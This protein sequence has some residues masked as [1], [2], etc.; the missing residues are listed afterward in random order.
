MNA[1]RLTPLSRHWQLLALLVAVLPQYDRLPPWLTVSVLAV[2]LWRLAPVERRLGVPGPWLRGLLLLAGMGGVLYS[3]HTLLGPEGGVSFL[4]VCALLKLLE[5]STPR[6]AFV[7]AVLDFFVLATAFLFSQA[8]LLTLYVGMASIVVVAALLSLQQRPGV[9]L[10]RTLRRAT[11]LVVQAVPLMLVLFVFFPRLPP[12]WTLNLTQGS[13]HTGMSDS[14]SPGDISSLSESA[15]TAF[16]VEFQGPPP[17]A[18]TLYWRGLVFSHFDGK[19][20]SQPDPISE[21]VPTR[22]QQVPR[23]V[24]G[25]GGGRPLSYRVILEATDQPWL[26]ALNVPRPVTAKVGLT[27][28][29]R[30]VYSEPVRSTLSYEVQSWPGARVDA[31][32]L[33]LWLR[34]LNLQ[35]PAGGNPEARRMAQGWRLSAGSDERYVRSILDWFRQE[36]FYYTLEAPPLGEDRIDD[37]LFRTRRGFCEHYASSF[38]FL[39]RAAGIPARV[40]AGYQGG[41]AGTLGDYWLVRQLDAHAWAEVWLPGRGWVRE[42]PTAAVAPV[43]IQKGADQVAAQRSYWGEGAAGALRHGN[44]RLLKGLRQFADY[45][46]YRWHRDVLGYDSQSQEGLM[47]RLLGDTGLLRRLA[48]MVAVLAA[49]AGLIFLWTLRSGQ[50]EQHPLD[51]LYRRYC[52]RLDRLG[53]R[54]EAGEPP[55][56]FARRVRRLRPS[57]GD[58]AEEFA[59]LYTALRYRPLEQQRAALEKRLRRLARGRLRDHLHRAAE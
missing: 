38:V 27:R 37:F 34:K 47:Q 57:L 4:I 22:G 48:V 30:L 56:A 23:W 50:R 8:L 9:G 58:E 46:N 1:G 39:M 41:E 32:E 18:D 15:A 49:L 24:S 45:L 3:H 31:D 11:A 55:Q 25:L 6:D 42:D 54:R 14:M 20:W 7:S 17:P 52:R 10:R 53:I 36:H 51:R 29:A 16:R 21:P 33:P 19:R 26:F 59:R 28:D 40:V 12:L 44:F 2:C 13:G 5:S 35:L 43:R